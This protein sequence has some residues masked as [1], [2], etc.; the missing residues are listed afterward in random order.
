[1]KMLLCIKQHLSNILSSTH[2]K[3]KQYWGW[4]AKSVVYKKSAYIM[5]AI[6]KSDCISDQQL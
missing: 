2:G 6:D 5:S 3:V 4:V 1:M